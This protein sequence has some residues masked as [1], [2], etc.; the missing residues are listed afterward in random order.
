MLDGQIAY[1]SL[2][3]FTASAAVDLRTAIEQ[4][5][6]QNPNGLILDLRNNTGGYLTSAIDIISFF[7]PDGMAAYEEF[8]DGTRIPQEVTGDVISSEIPM[9]ILVNEWSASASEIVAGALQ[10]RGRAQIVGVTTFGKGTV[11][12]WISLSDDQ[13]AVKITSARWLTPNGNSVDGTGVT[14]DYVVEFTE[15]DM[16]AE[17]D[18]QLDQAIELLNQP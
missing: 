11:Q 10:D 18:P 15:E 9:V 13:G 17:V 1:V 3:T 5:M 8:G 6:A 4:L 16:L 2:S 14:P 12:S 7:L